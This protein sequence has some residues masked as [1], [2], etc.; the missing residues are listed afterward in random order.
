MLLQQNRLAFIGLMRA[1]EDLGIASGMSLLYLN[2][3]TISF[4]LG[5]LLKM[6]SVFT[7]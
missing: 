6:N 2:F 1:Q 4:I 3:V 7:I 5:M